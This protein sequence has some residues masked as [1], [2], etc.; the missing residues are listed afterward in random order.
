MESETATKSKKKQV[1]KNHE[2]EVLF[3]TIR[4][5]TK[6]CL[7]ARRGIL[8]SKIFKCPTFKGIRPTGDVPDAEPSESRRTRLLAT[9]QSQPQFTEATVPRRQIA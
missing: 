8:I 7:V 3:N 5:E 2:P 9:P 4:F 1:D 6:G